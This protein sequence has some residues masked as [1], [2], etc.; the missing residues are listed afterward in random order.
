PIP[1]Q[2]PEE[3]EFVKESILLPIILDVLER[4]RTAVV[5]AGLKLPEIYSELIE[6]LQ[7]AATAE[8]TRARQGLRQH[9]MKIYKERRT[10]LGIEADYLCRGYHY[11]FSMLWGLVKA[12]ILQRIR[13]YLSISPGGSLEVYNAKEGDGS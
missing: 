11:E 10:V 13:S 3:A 5:R 2:T 12:E 1:W 7:K 9:G 6:L 4:D 8:L